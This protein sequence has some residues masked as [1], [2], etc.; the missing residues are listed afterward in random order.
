[1]LIFLGIVLMQIIITGGLGP[2]MKKIM[3]ARCPYED[4]VFDYGRKRQ[5]CED[6]H[7]GNYV[8]SFFWPIMVPFLISEYFGR[9]YSIGSKAERIETRRQRELDEAKHKTMLAAERAKQLDVMEREAGIK[10]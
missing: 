2:S 10:K 1:M 6:W 8:A 7:D 9:K 5:D 3:I 4:H